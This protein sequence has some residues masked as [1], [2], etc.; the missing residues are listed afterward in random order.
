MAGVRSRA[1][2]PPPAAPAIIDLRTLAL[3]PMLA[4]AFLNDPHTRTIY[5]RHD[6]IGLLVQT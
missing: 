6:R 2:D 3:K 5:L 4:A 1:S